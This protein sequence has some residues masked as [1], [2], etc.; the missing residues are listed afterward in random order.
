ME[1][2]TLLCMGGMVTATHVVNELRMENFRK[3][4]GL[5]KSTK[6]VIVIGMVHVNALPG[7]YI[8]FCMAY[9][10]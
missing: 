6:R 10:L 1:I 2:F 8:T 3:L 7:R 5:V 9:K 4:F